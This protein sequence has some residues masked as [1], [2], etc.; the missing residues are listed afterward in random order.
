MKEPQIAELL[1]PVVAQL[2]L[3]LEAV[4]LIPAGKRRL[5]RLVIDGDGPD[6][7]GPSLDNIA[8]ATKA[9]S[10][11]LDGADITGTSPY[12]L[13]V[14]TRGVG[15]PLDRPQHWRR[16]VGRL[17]ALTTRAGDKLTGRIVSSS[18]D[19]VQLDVQTVKRDVDFSDVAKAHV[20]VELNRTSA[21]KED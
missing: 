18:E 14:S 13:E 17:V 4:E 10:A 20:Q 2:D 6:G 8:E 7:R 1:G 15:R 12:T 3:E 16:N 21:E 19:S 11:V 5:L 9:I